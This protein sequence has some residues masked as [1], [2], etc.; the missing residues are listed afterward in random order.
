[1]SA[2]WDI[3]FAK[4]TH[5]FVKQIADGWTVA[6]L[7]IAETGIP[8]SL[9][10]STNGYAIS[11]RAVSAKGGIPKGAPHSMPTVGADDYIYTPF[12]SNNH[13]SGNPT[14]C[15][16]PLFD[17]SYVNPIMGFSDWGPFPAT[18][19]GRN[20]FRGPGSWN[21]DLGIYKMFYLGERFRLQFRGELYNSF[22]HANFER[23]NREQRHRLWVHV[24]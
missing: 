22:N 5:G 7:F 16:I 14:A 2:V 19:T 4:S 10:D 12:Y 23:T 20:A 8:F 1:M 17:S 21:L 13:S 3:P 11:M 6:P 18:M 15:A 9:Y 24:S